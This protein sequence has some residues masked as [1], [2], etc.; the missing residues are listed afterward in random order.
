MKPAGND[1]IVFL[2]AKRTAFGAFNGTLKKH[3]ATG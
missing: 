2:S 1:D 3:S